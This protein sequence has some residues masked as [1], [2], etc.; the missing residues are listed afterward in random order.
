MVPNGVRGLNYW[1]T[2]GL[3]HGIQRYR[4]IELHTQ[5]I[6]GYSHG[7]WR[8]MNTNTKILK[9]YWLSDKDHNLKVVDEIYQIH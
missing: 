1:L 9:D 3:I 2:R 4:R 8:G 7:I 6:S 5:F